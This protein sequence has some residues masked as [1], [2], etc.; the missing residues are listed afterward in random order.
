MI[1]NNKATG[2]KEKN[3]KKNEK[4]KKEKKKRKIFFIPKFE[5]HCLED[6]II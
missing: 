3:E 4:K 2:K 6:S 1:K 5:R